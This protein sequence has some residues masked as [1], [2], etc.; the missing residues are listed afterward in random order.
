MSEE[1]VN[2]PVDFENQS[3]IYDRYNRH[4]KTYEEK[5]NLPKRKFLLSFQC[6][7]EIEK[8]IVVEAYDEEDAWDLLCADAT[9]RE[10][11]GDSPIPYCPYLNWKTNDNRGIISWG[12]PDIMEIDHEESC[13]EIEPEFEQYF[14]KAVG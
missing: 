5:K 14:P 2:A 1:Y 3:E 12:E 4:C 8:E 9:R 11:L 13:M 7:V 6:T 10:N